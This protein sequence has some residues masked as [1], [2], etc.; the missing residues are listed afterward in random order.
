V[1]RGDEGADC[2]T[3]TN[4]RLPGK[5]NEEVAGRLKSGRIVHITGAGHNVRR[6]GKEQ[7]LQVLREFL[8]G[9]GGS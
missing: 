6:E 2:A 1:R 7:T 4:R 9:L 8:G 3:V 5:Q